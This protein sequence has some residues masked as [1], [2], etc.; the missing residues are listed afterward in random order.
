MVGKNRRRK[1]SRSKFMKVA[2]A[3]RGEPGCRFPLSCPPRCRIAGL[4]LARGMTGTFCRR[5][6]ERTIHRSCS[7]APAGLQRAFCCRRKR[8]SEKSRGSRVSPAGG[9]RGLQKAIYVVSCGVVASDRAAWISRSASRECAFVYRAAH[10]EGSPGLRGARS[11]RSIPPLAF[12]PAD[13]NAK[14][15]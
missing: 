10:P 13:V 12:G 14:Q 15:S 6:S 7:P 9:F 3:R 8:P 11:V 1:E 2:E 4:C 5:R